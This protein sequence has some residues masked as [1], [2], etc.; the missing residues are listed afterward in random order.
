MTVFDLDRSVVDDYARFATS[1]TKISAGDLLE[2]VR[3]AYIRGHF[4]PDPMVQI[5]PKFKSGPT[6]GELVSD[7]ALHPGCRDIFRNDHDPN[8]GFQLHHHQAVALGLAKQ[9]KSFVVTTGTGSGKS[10]CYFLPIIDRILLAKATP[11]APR[12][13]AIVIYPMNALANSQFEEIA[14][15]VDPSPYKGKVTFASYT[16]QERD[17]QRQYVRQNPPD[18]LLTNFMM[19]ELLLTRQEDLDKDV[20]SNCEGLEFLVLDELHTYRGRQGADVAMLV[21]RVRDRLER[22]ASPIQCI[23][24]SATMAS[25]MSDGKAKEKV[26][27]VASLLF[28]T[29]IT[30]AEVVTEDL[31]R[32]TDTTLT[33]HSISKKALA[34][35]I[36][37]FDGQDASNAVLAENAFFAW[38]EMTM[39]LKAGDADGMTLRRA[40]PLDLENAAE[41]LS[42]ASGLA[43]L[44]CKD[45][46]ELALEIAGR[47]ESERGGA[48]S[49]PFFPVRLHRFIS[50]AGR[51]FSTLEPPG[52]R[53]V[54]FD[55]QQ[56]MPGRE[57]R[58][59]LFATYFC[60]SCGQEHHPVRKVR[61]EEG[62]TFHARAID[63]TAVAE[64]GDDEGEGVEFAGFLTP[65][66]NSDMTS[67]EGRVDQYPEEWLE[68]TRA[69]EL[70]LRT[71]YRDKALERTR[72]G[73]DGAVG[74]GAVAWFQKGKF[75]F[76]AACGT[77]HTSA[78]R[79]INRLAGLSAEGRSS[80]TTI[81]VGAII[82][83]MR[84]NAG[85]R[86]TSDDAFRS[87]VL[88]FTDN[89]QDA[90]LQAGH[91]NDF[92]FI[93]LLRAGVLAALE[94]SGDAGLD[95]ATIG[96][97]IAEAMRFVPEEPRLYAEW[98]DDPELGA[99]DPHHPAV[100]EAARTLAGMLRHRFWYDQRRGWRYTFPNLEQLGLINVEYKGLDTLAQSD[101]LDVKGLAPL[102]ALS[103]EKRRAA[104]AAL[105]DAARTGLSVRTDGLDRTQLDA[106]L[107]RRHRL[108]QPWG[109]GSEERLEEASVL[110]IGPA[111]P[112]RNAAESARYVRSGIQSNVGRTLR[113]IVGVSVSGETYRMLVV[114]MGRRLRESGLFVPQ[115][116][117]GGAEGYQLA[118]DAVVFRASPEGGDGNKFFTDLY[119]ALSRRLFQGSDLVFGNEARE[120][121]AQVES[122]RR[123][124]RERRFRFNGKEQAALREDTERL[125]NPD[126]RK[127]F[128]PVLFCS[129]TMELGVDIAELDA[130][131]LR[132]V[133]PTPANYAQRSGRAGR[134]GSAALVLTY[135]SAQSP[136]DQYYFERRRDMIQGIVRP[137]A[138]EL[139]NQ[140]LVDSHLNAIWLAEMGHPLG[141][142]ISE[143]VDPVPA[144]RPLRDEI[145][146]ASSNPLV[147]ERATKRMSRLLT[148][149]QR[150]FGQRLPP[151]FD[152][153]EAYAD[154]IASSAS[155]KFDQSFERWR[156]LLAG[157]EAQ[158]N[159]ARR[160]LDDFSIRDAAVKR[161]ADRLNYLAQSQ[162]NALLDADERQS[163]DMYTYRYLATEGFLPGYN[164]PRLPLIAFI[165]AQGGNGKNTFLQRPRFLAISEFGP[166]SRIYHEGR[167][168]R[169][170][171][172]QLPASE[173]AAD[174][175]RLVTE[176]LWLCQS[177]GACHAQEPERCHACGRAEGWRPIANVRRIENL[178]TKP[179]DM[180]TANDEE[181]QRQGFELATTFS[182]AKRGVR[183]DRLRSLV[184]GPEDDS[185]A[186]ISF[187]GAA[188]L[189]RLNLGLRRRRERND[190]GFM[191]EPGSGLWLN[192]QQVEEVGEDDDANDMIRARP[193]RIVPMVEDRKNALLLRP[194]DGF[195]SV[196]SASVIQYALLRGI[197]L[198][199]QLEE[200]ELLAEAMPDRNERKGILFYESTE[201]GAGVLARVA[202][203]TD[204]LK[205]A[206]SRAL[207]LMHYK[208]RGDVWR[209]DDLDDVGA[210]SC[211]DACYRCLLSYFNQPE[212]EHLDRHNAAA[213]NFLCAVAEGRT[214]PLDDVGEEVVQPAKSDAA[215]ELF[216]ARLAALELVAPK[217]KP[218]ADGWILLWSSYRLA[219]LF[220]AADKE[221]G[222]Y[223]DLDFEVIVCNER[224]DSWEE[225]ATRVAA[226]LG[227]SKST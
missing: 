96:Q 99:G 195:D 214:E 8:A 19:L 61:D 207:E 74:N 165:P 158:R 46:L 144:K 33:P 102:V 140:D 6:I 164:F 91:Y 147:K 51:L 10:T 17:E 167:A 145:Q 160:I 122:S 39:G 29:T 135:C 58:S 172:A 2:K 202:R 191:I 103:S 1:F 197:E 97:K 56:F 142:R 117:P 48:S 153:A 64:T 16:G 52:E 150:E 30:E 199:Y 84:E 148:Q 47:P 126:E 53:D 69:G 42:Q 225:A 221:P 65:V 54:T 190:L 162:I 66:T 101:P 7:G 81:L 127:T 59:R 151:W 79:D 159:E 132:N 31:R 93:T 204:G 193:Q 27:A 152:S 43:T 194:I 18:I 212:H 110:V 137:P 192:A 200:G 75:S 85:E 68:T 111:P 196:R 128:L 9:L 141:G 87:K 3:E 219:V 104:Y 170:V 201:G 106:L 136:H 134:G 215:I 216:L 114:A 116:L 70:R 173:L 124:I 226:H 224:T 25:G 23:G 15:R 179:A 182:W 105:L 187:S 168:Y 50:G 169:I 138:I 123:R 211:V 223:A 60:R 175:G 100:R 24:T 120:H 161:G 34:S 113:K 67:F 107:S 178:S 90:A 76:C 156:T 186:E 86:N 163:S 112:T 5:N 82:R 198:E 115:P 189:R 94:A 210:S 166:H 118:A 177:C 35:A 73:V 149:L 14:K 12:T 4:W 220:G 98:M 89:R 227:G 37:R 157:A 208:P 217:L 92:A 78:G 143:V 154:R 130:V 77:T 22:E 203:E 62:W 45:K 95:D 183:Y 109:F 139:A 205:R 80:A 125:R 119:R 13:R 121:T 181:R 174:G 188:T 206:A 36:K 40:E 213:L 108:A 28:A 146:K 218:S 222:D 26:A 88:G 32:V 185:L 44:L 171:R 209:S 63:D 20:L 71:A 131:Y 55:G 176:Q 41:L 49:Q 133:P 11:Q 180:I 129:P 155:Q 83:W 21:R 57:Q 72:V 38:I 184:K